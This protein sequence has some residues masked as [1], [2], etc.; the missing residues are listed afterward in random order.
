MY[1]MKHYIF[2]L[3]RSGSYEFTAYLPTL[4]RVY[5]FVNSDSIWLLSWDIKN[6]N[7]RNKNIF[8]KKDK[9]RDIKIN[10]YLG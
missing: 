8:D 9:E 1:G 2:P 3:F 6:K 10:M 5:H 4:I 7:N